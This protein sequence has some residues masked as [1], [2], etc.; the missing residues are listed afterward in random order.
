MGHKRALTTVSVIT[1]QFVKF[2]C[3]KSG[4]FLNISSS[5]C[6][7]IPNVQSSKS[8]EVMDFHGPASAKQVCSPTTI[9]L[10][11]KCFNL[12]HR[13]ANSPIV[14]SVIGHNDRSILR[15]CAPSKLPKLKS[16]SGPNSW[17][18]A[19]TI[20]SRFTFSSLSSSCSGSYEPN[21]D[22]GRTVRD[23]MS[24]EVPDFVSR[25]RT[26][27]WKASLLF[28]IVRGREKPGV[29]GEGAMG[30]RDDGD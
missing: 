13:S 8:S 1:L 30:R 10:I 16:D 15:M 6:W 2:K 29:S 19:R 28:R 3:S 9:P 5:C 24:A 20:V 14:L 11:D 27:N 7:S 26:L 12:R 23:G 4:R 21:M 22:V 18:P 17:H 25:E